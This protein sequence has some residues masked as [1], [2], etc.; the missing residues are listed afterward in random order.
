MIAIAQLG[1]V[2][3]RVG[4]GW[5]MVWASAAIMFHVVRL[6]EKVVTTYENQEYNRLVQARSWLWL[7]LR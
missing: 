4:S 7:R 3:V 2:M 5:V 6:K 1:M